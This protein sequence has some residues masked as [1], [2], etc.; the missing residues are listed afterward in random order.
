MSDQELARLVREYREAV[1]KYAEAVRG[2]E[3]LRGSEFDEAYKKVETL[4]AVTER[5]RTAVKKYNSEAL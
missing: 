3:G 4:L 2:L 1:T 5:C